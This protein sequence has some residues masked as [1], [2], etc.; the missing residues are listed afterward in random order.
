MAWKYSGM[1]SLRLNH[2]ILMVLMALNNLT[3]ARAPNSPVIIVGTHYDAVGESFSP[4]KAEEL[5]Q[6]IREKFIAIPDAE[7]VGLP[8]VID[9]IEISCRYI[10]FNILKNW[11]N[12]KNFASHFTALS[13][14][15]SYSPT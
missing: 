6:I 2:Q 3:Q 14:I 15:L 10:H 5:Q 9:S 12:F 8:R 1:T 11:A 13:T 4:Q 7:K